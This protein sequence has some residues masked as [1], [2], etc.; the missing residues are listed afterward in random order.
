MHLVLD[1][2]CMAVKHGWSKRRMNGGVNEMK[3]EWWGGCVTWHWRIGNR[4]GVESIN[5]VMCRSRLR[6]FGHVERM[7]V[8]SC[9]KRCINM[10]GRRARG[11]PRK[12]CDV[13]LRDD[14][15]VKGPTRGWARD[16]AAWKAAIRWT[17][18]YTCKHGNGRKTMMMMMRN[19]SG[20]QILWDLNWNTF[21]LF[22]AFRTSYPNWRI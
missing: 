3:W 12:T 21:F 22:V 17:T 14:L 9:V 1:V 5:E 20:I 13:L 8:G 2:C 10:N 15:G 19:W 6:W 11:H 4:F 16:C 18:A 7:W